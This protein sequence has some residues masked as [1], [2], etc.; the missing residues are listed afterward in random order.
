MAPIQK[1][2]EAAK[3]VVSK[4][5][6]KTGQKVVYHPVGGSMQLTEGIIKGIVTEPSTVGNTQRKVKAS[7][8]EPRI[9]I[10]N[11]H[12]HKETAYKPEN[13]EKIVDD[14]EGGKIRGK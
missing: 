2:G 7:N 5:D 14:E 13:I 10:E 3:P 9:V 1:T 4:E 11:L 8:E 12:T 6:L